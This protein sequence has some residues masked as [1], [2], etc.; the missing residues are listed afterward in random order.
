MSDNHDADVPCLWKGDV[1]QLDKV[2]ANTS[3]T[4]Q[5][6]CK[7]CYNQLFW[8]TVVVV[9]KLFERSKNRENVD[10]R[11]TRHSDSKYEQRMQRERDERKE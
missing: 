9:L 10:I 11:V 4:G 3:K 1:R 7:W 6:L 5:N 8:M 2:V